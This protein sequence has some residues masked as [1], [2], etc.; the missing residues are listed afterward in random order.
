MSSS[1]GKLRAAKVLLPT[2]KVL[3]RPLN[4][5]Y[6][7]E[8]GSV[9]EIERTQDGEQLK[10]TEVTSTTLHPTRAAATRARTQIQRLLSSEIGTFSWLGSVAEF[11]RTAGTG[12]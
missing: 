1:D 7:L 3:K 4:L 2:K 5:L 12:N 11:P 10:E 8:C 9:Q 6:P